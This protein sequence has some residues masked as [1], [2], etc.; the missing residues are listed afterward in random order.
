[1]LI[2]DFVILYVVR[3]LL[4]NYDI[5]EV[6]FLP[7][8]RCNLN[9]KHCGQIQDIKEEDE[10]DCSL[11]LKKL[12]ESLFLKT[13]HIVVSGGEPFL[14]DTFGDFI[15]S[16]MKEGRFMMSITSNGFFTE[17]IKNVVRKIPRRERHRIVFAISV[18]GLADVHNRIRGNKNSFSYAVE[19]VKM[20]S[21]YGISVNINVVAQESNIHILDDM[22]S[23]FS[24]IHE[25]IYLAVIPIAIDISKSGIKN[26]SNS[27]FDMKN[28]AAMPNNNDTY[29][30]EYRE[31]LWK[32]MS[33]QMRKKI[34]ASRGR[35]FIPRHCC[36]AGNDNI[37]INADGSVFTCLTGATYKIGRKNDFLIGN[38]KDKTLDEI[39][40]DVEK[41]EKVRCNVLEC[42]GCSNPCELDR[43]IRHGKSINFSADEIDFVYRHEKKARVGDALLDLGDWYEV[44]QNGSNS[45]C[46]S[47]KKCAKI[48]VPAKSRKI[49]IS[50][51][52]FNNSQNVKII[53][54]GGE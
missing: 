24:A 31:I 6:I 46:W 10:I 8:V 42:D 26:L 51:F 30:D 32:K 33:S 19:T 29:T 54:R 39:F 28:M 23:F 3:M 27:E 45:W 50:Y 18:D 12:N 37:L 52:K 5:N 25:N 49:R 21:H 44:E 9:C 22:Q 53:Y 20:L 7:S 34:L 11:V 47:A 17:K 40:S 36:T 14:N 41:R 35:Y 13:N 48:F 15:V 2:Y 1:M 16:V 4:M 43:A 38:L